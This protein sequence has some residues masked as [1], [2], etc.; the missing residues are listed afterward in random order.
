MQLCRDGGEIIVAFVYRAPSFPIAESL[1]SMDNLCNKLGSFRMPSVVVGDFKFNLL[2][3]SSVGNLKFLIAM[4]LAD[5]L[6][7]ITTPTCVT[8]FSA[9]LI[10][11]IF[12]PQI[13]YE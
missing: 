4:L 11:D 7:S 6:P 12:L 10:N 9:M 13:W 3:L 1:A 5:F 8:L 2:E